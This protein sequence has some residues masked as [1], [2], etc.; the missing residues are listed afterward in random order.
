MDMG[1]TQPLTEA[2]TRNIPGDKGWSTRKADNTY[3]HV[4]ADRL[5]KMW[6]P[7]RLTT[8]WAFTACYR[9]NFTFNFLTIQ[10]TL[11]LMWGFT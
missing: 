7:Q 5:E 1:S 11:Y 4:W 3:R 9:D 10:C 8:L 6:E 2:T